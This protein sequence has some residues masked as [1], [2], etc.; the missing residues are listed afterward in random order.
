MRALVAAFGGVLPDLAT[1]PLLEWLDE[2]SALHWDFRNGAERFEARDWDGAPELNAL[3]LDSARALGLVVPRAPARDGYDHLL[4][5]GGLTAACLQ[6]TAYAALVIA[7]GLTVGEVA[8][9]GSFRPLNPA[10]LARL[11]A[12]G[13]RYEVDALDLGVREAFGLATPSTRRGSE[14]PPAPES[15][16]HDTYEPAGRT[17]VHVLAAPASGHRANTA[18]TYEFWADRLRVQPGSTVLI[19]TT[20]IYVPFQHGDAVRILSGIAGCHVETVGLDQDRL[21]PGMR[22]EPFSPGRHLQEIRS[23]IRSMHRLYESAR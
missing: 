23:A 12:D 19:V 20:P 8:A 16:R 21:A 4:V 22:G 2:F 15:W 10:E 1:G 9:L 7:G 18:D 5:L 11:G 3:V 14:G 13:D 17:P 6:R